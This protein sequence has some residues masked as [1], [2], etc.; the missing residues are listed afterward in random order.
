MLIAVWADATF[1]PA[2]ESESFRQEVDLSDDY[3]VIAVQDDCTE[4]EIWAV[5]EAWASLR[6]C[7]NSA[8]RQKSDS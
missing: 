5:A 4:D 2:E 7:G 6:S 3:K 8:E 1:C